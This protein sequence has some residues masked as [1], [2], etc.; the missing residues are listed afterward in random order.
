MHFPGVSAQGKQKA[1]AAILDIPLL[2][3]TGGEKRCDYVLC[4]T[5]PVVVQMARVMR[6]PGM[7]A[8][9]LKAILARQMP[10]AKKRKFADYVIDTGG[11]RAASKTTIAH[12]IL[13][14]EI[15]K[16]L[17]MREIVLDTET[18]LASISAAGAPGGRNRLRRIIQPCGD[19]A[20]LA[21][22]S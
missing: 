17:G 18:G 2:F 16:E 13:Q 10:D 21:E 3:E 4:V 22:L 20:H 8:A 11:S 1:A 12:G 15:L 6:R 19:W 5:A 9:I 14:V 7:T